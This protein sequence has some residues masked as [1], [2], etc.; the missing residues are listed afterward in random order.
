[1]AARVPPSGDFW[2]GLAAMLVA[3]PASI[4]FG[5]TVY[6]ALGPAHAA[7]GALAGIIGATVIGLIASWLGGTDRLISAPCA[8]AAAVLSAFAIEL[9]RSG[10]EPGHVV[11]LLILVGILGGLIQLGLGLLGVGG[12]IKYIPYP[13]V[14]GYLTA[15]GLIIMGSQIPKFLGVPSDMPWH[16]ALRAP[17]QWDWRAILIAT[18]TAVVATTAPRVI[19]RVPGIILGILAGILTYFGLVVADPALRQLADNPLVIGQVGIAGDGLWG[20]VTG[21]WAEIGEVVLTNGLSELATAM[22]LGVLLSIDTLKTSVVLDKLTRS[23]HD[24]NRELMAQGV[25]NVAANALGG[26][27]GAGQM[28]ATLVG[29]NAGSVSKAAGVVEGVL[30][31]VAALLLSQFI[32]W[33]PVATLAGILVVIGIRMI[34]REPLQFLESKETVLDFAVVL[35]VVVVALTVSL[36]AASAVG[37]GLAMILFVREQ[38]GASVVRHKVGLGQT[39]SS[40]HRPEREVAVLE[41]NG[42]QAVVFEL[43]GSVF[44]GNTYQLYADLEHEISTRSYVIID[45]RRVRSIDVTAAQLFRHI[46]DTIRER[47]A[48]LV[49]SGVRE[50]HRSGRNLREFLGQSGVWHPHS[51]TVRIFADLDAAIG[52]V[53]DRLIGA[54]E[55]AAEN[56]PP[57]ALREMD[58]FAQHK[59]ETI[60]EL[61][62]RMEIRHF[63][64]GATIY[65]RGTPGDE[66]YWV[67]RGKVRLVAP[68]EA[69]KTK[70]VASFGRGD[71]FGGLAFMDNQPRPHDAVALT[72]TEVYVLTRS[73]F[74]QIVNTHRK[75]AFNLANSMAGTFAMRLRRAER[76]LAILQDF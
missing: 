48:K 1:M 36:I 11:A 21:G 37:V 27:S 57:M 25:A 2:G 17:A 19:Q 69:S 45:L 64:A 5:V 51:K 53:E 55:E 66:L 3:L 31:L 39:S 9:V 12:L 20:A 35:A 23:H 4:A 42:D 6:A 14:S 56:E 15:V 26:I 13:V 74:E 68:L 73:N 43:Q 65:A 72:A 40:W 44:F 58:L 75:L 60:R 7:Y 59:D 61:E 16:E 76:K 70:Q 32:A 38:V 46:R 54:L 33:M 52:W 8:P 41:R 49:F 34:D 62:A 67:R 63:E 24:S 30:A 47:G 18:V 50:H 28:G 22:T 10:V 71:F 29:L